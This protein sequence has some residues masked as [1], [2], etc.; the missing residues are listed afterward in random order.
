MTDK[1][2]NGFLLDESVMAEAEAGYETNMH[3]NDE[4]DD[5]NS[6]IARQ[7]VQE[8]NT[9]ERDIFFFGCQCILANDIIYLRNAAEEWQIRYSQ[10]Q[11]KLLLYHKNKRK[12]RHKRI[13][14][15]GYHEQY[16][17]CVR[18]KPTI[19]EYIIYASLHKMKIEKEKEKP[20]KKRK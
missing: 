13:A 2:R 1:N 7:W 8:F 3:E 19:K 9:K 20:K 6:P 14:V 5:F 10:K 12:D 4:D 16:V 11:N 17:P 15:K 18:I